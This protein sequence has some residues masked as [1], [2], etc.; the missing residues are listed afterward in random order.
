ML[1]FGVL[2]GHQRY[3]LLKY[4]IVLLIVVGVIMFNYKDGSGRSSGDAQ[5]KLFDLI[6]PGEF[7][8]VSERR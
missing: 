1:F 5:W 2:I 7:L 8:V 6:G 3:P 4:L